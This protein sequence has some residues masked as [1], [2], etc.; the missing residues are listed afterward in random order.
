MI[1]KKHLLHGFSRL[2]AAAA[3]CPCFI[4]FYC[5]LP[6][7]PMHNPENVRLIILPA[8]TTSDSLTIGDTLK[9][10]VA[11]EL[12]H[13]IDSLRITIGEEYDSLYTEI[14]ETLSV[15]TLPNVPGDLPIQI[16]GYCH[17]DI[18]KN[19]YD[20]LYV[21]SIPV[22]IAEEPRDGAVFEGESV[23]F[24]IEVSGNPTPTIQWFR[25]ST[26]ID[27]ATGD[28]LLIES[29]S[30]DMDGYAY[31]AR[32]ANS[33]DTVWSKEALLSINALVSRWDEMVWDKA[34]WR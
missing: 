11:V 18:V 30:L 17:S 20:T 29:A 12:S 16:T 27:G 23:L 32:V 31:Y 28:T 14:T 6:D 9:F 33:V 3:L 25:D 22:V 15:A 21:M 7:D 5:S 19:S 1:R 4:A 10:D 2:F 13:L 8:D 24:F 34:V 26:A